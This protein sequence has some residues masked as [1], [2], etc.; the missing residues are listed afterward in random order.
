MQSLEKIEKTEHDQ[1]FSF[2]MSAFRVIYDAVEEKPFTKFEDFLKSEKFMEK[3]WSLNETMEIRFSGS[4]DSG[5]IDSIPDDIDFLEMR[6]LCFDFVQ[7][8]STWDWYDN[9]GGWVD[10]HINFLRQK[11]EL[12]GGYYVT[13]EEYCE[14]DVFK[15]DR[16][17]NFKNNPYH[18]TI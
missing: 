11:I 3:Y 2:F 4:G 10:L 5:D 9:E 7:R 14:E 6:D 15:P 1:A 18:D 13:R 12:S 17:I 16:F 8:H